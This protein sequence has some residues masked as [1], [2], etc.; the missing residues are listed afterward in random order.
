MK[1][2]DIRQMFPSEYICH[3]DLI[4]GNG[5]RHK[6]SVVIDRIEEKELIL[7]G[8]DR[9][10][11]F[12]IHFRPKSV[13][14]KRPWQPKP[15]VLNSTHK[16]DIA[17][18]HGPDPSK[19]DGKEIELFVGE[20]KAPPKWKPV[21]GKMMP[22]IRIRAKSAVGE[23]MKEALRASAEP[24]QAPEFDDDPDRGP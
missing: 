4:D 12:V 21:Y 11:G 17:S 20:S 22:A 7:T 3:A 2:T 16:I 18:Q 10:F 14:G 19:W 9:K 24:V 13:Q 15:L 8:G 1:I 5:K 6:V 23:D